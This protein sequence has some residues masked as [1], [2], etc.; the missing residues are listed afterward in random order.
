MKKLI[1]AAL[2]MWL[3]MIS[4]LPAGAYESRAALREAYCA[5]GDSLKES[6]YA[7]EP[8]VSAPYETGAL[9]E[10][11]VDDALAYLNFLRSVAGLEPV[12]RSRI[13]DYQC[14]HGA[15]LLAAL[16]Y[17]DHSAP[18]PEDMDAG[19]Y[20]SAHLA[21]TSS[22]LAGFNWMR[23]TIL[24]EGLAYFLRD[25][26]AGNLSVLGHRRWALNPYM[27]ATGFGL[28]NS[29]IGM[30]YVVMYAHDFGNMDVR[31]EQVLW[32]S[33]GYF[34]V[35]LMRRELAWSVMLNAQVYDMSASEICVELWEENLNLSFTFNCTEGRGDGFCTVDFGRYGGG[36]C[37]IFRPS[38]P[39]DT[40]T[41]Y[42][43]NQRWQ[44]RVT[45]LRRMDGTETEL[46]Y[47]V[48]MAALTV[49]EAVNVEMS[50]LEAEL[51]AGE[52]LRLTADVIPSYADDLSVTW[53]SSD[54]RVATVEGGVV[55]AVSAGECS[56]TAHSANGRYDTCMLR[57]TE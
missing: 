31:W 13:Y 4:A 52:T 24:R 53:R 47:T 7:Q 56:I 40:F 5:L 27:G 37:V 8:G 19:F 25:D 22:N 28:A 16:D 2:A 21:T 3:L 23:P 39:E 42:Q 29:K 1:A 12:A 57:V 32:P 35:E 54:E 26:G 11:A 41:D 55:T 18:K 45:G 36:P 15:V 50:A 30:S 46:E 6:P 51:S 17:A 20:E 44:V 48:N 43:Q 9:T 49:Q 33:E 10:Q 14:Q 38:F 34:P